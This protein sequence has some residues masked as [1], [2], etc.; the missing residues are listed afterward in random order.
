[1][2]EHVE[3]I[4]NFQEVPVVIDVVNCGNNWFW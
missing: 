2:Y 1:M 4:H 3:I